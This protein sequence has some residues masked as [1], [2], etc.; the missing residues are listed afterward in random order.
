MG[1]L[2]GGTRIGNNVAVHEGMYNINFNYL[3]Q[4]NMTGHLNI[5]GYGNKLTIGHD[6]SS[7]THFIT[8]SPK[9][10]F[11]KPG[12]FVQ[13]SIYAGANYNDL[14]LTTGNISSQGGISADMVDGFHVDDTKTGADV[15]TNNA[16]WTAN[17][18]NI[19]IQAMK[20]EIL[21]GASAA[22]DTLKEIQDAIL[23][24]QTGFSALSA[25]IETK[26]DKTAKAVDSDKLDGLDSTVFKRRAQWDSRSASISDMTKL[27]SYSMTG[28]TQATFI[29]NFK[30]ESVGTGS[31]YVD[32]TGTSMNINVL[33]Y[34]GTSSCEI[35]IHK[36]SANVYT[37]FIRGIVGSIT[38][39]MENPFWLSTV[40]YTS[41]ALT[42]VSTDTVLVNEITTF[43][44]PAI[45]SQANTFKQCQKFESKSKQYQD[46]APGVD[47]SI[48]A[49]DKIVSG[50]DIISMGAMKTNT[51]QLGRDINTE[52]YEFE[53]RYNKI[54]KR[55][56]FNF[57]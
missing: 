4:L 17:K 47:A 41:G 25:K 49:S 21:G 19:Q 30:L 51:V 1:R 14:V 15:S 5:T 45:M 10:F 7:Y 56:E 36:T 8:T 37:I 33:H 54:T 40:T 3:E 32:I 2:N 26:L 20:S 13:G 27:F 42:V 11:F 9:G 35:G 43:S 52:E 16:L 12:L 34:Y 44:N 53:M 22:Y 46:P 28:T 29:L 6:N 38:C 23:N 50:D 24:D 48:K 39:E 55:L 18:V 57:L 31:V